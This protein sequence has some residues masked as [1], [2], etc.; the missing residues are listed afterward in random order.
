MGRGLLRRGHVGCAMSG[1]AAVV[2]TFIGAGD[3]TIA[4]GA[5]PGG[6]VRVSVSD[7]GAQAENIVGCASIS[8]DGRYV[9]FCSYSPLVAGDTNGKLDVFV[10]DMVAGTIKRVS[11]SS[12]ETQ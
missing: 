7:T 1:V 8:A 11:V 4:V 3:P 2:L 9:G 6:V 10:R 5:N 12:D